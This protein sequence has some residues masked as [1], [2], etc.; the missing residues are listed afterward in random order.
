MRTTSARLPSPTPAWFFLRLKIAASRHSI[1]GFKNKGKLLMVKVKGQLLSLDAAGSIAKTITYSSWKGRPYAKQFKLPTQPNTPAQLGLRMA[2]QFLSQA[3]KDMN[4]ARKAEWIPKATE[5]EITAFDAYIQTNLVRFGLGLYPALTVNVVDGA[6]NLGITFAVAGTY[7]RYID[8][9]IN[10]A[11]IE[12]AWGYYLYAS[13]S[14]DDELIPSHV[15][16][17]FPMKIRGTVQTLR[18]VPTEIGSRYYQLVGFRW[19][20]KSQLC[21]SQP[22][23]SWPP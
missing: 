3:W 15:E 6:A 4:N 17:C 10:N 2:M 21:P 22:F 19:Q 8:F 1:A 16:A 13:D 12:K 9:E 18:F 23:V 5:G 20:S 7:E 11:G 14:I